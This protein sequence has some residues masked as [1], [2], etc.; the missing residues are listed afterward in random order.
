MG[1]VPS[2]CFLLRVMIC[3]SPSPP[4]FYL[5][6]DILTGGGDEERARWSVMEKLLTMGVCVCV[7][8]KSKVVGSDK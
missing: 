1:I 7:C 4:L 8:V 5:K 2:S 3:R 6:M